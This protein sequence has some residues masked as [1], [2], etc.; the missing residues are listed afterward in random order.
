MLKIYIVSTTRDAKFIDKWIIA[1]RRALP[2]RDT[3]IVTVSVSPYVRQIADP[4][5]KLI[6]KIWKH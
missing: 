3:L 1:W 6:R 2:S 5:T 4:Q